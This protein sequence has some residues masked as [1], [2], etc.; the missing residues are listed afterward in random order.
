MNTRAIAT[1]QSND[2]T[3]Q[4][5][6]SWSNV[7]VT[8]APSSRPRHEL[9]MN[10]SGCALANACTGPGIVTMGTNALEMNENG[11][12]R[13]LRPCAACALPLTRPS[14]ANTIANARAYTTMRPSASATSATVV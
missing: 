12:A 6:R 4:Y 7:R 3:T 5:V 14:H 11:T 2:P 9:T 13:M 10:V 8:S 1:D